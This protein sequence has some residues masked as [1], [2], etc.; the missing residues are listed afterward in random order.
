MPKFIIEHLEE[1]V[2]DW[3]FIEY[4]SMSKIV[5]KEN[6]IIT[7]LKNPKDR[8]KLEPFCEAK[9]E[10]VL[11]MNLNNTC[12]LDMGAEKELSPDDK[13]EYLVFGGIL[14]D[15]PPQ[16]RT[17]KFL[18]NLK[19]EKRHLGKV[20]MS[21]DN[22]VLTAKLIAVDKKSF[23]KIKFI[24]NPEIPM[25]DGLELRLPYRFVEV[26]GKPYISAELLLHIKKSGF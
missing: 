5:G 21:T 25:E 14:G 11:K 4:K 6:L 7:N 1:E 12:L 2:Y 23:E 13:F 20:Q 3:C 9:E 16:E 24:D 17:V 8:E 18:A 26:D 22:A 10:S 15:N 19:S